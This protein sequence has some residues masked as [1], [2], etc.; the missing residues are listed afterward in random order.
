MLMGKKAG[1]VISLP[2]SA[3]SYSDLSCFC[4]YREYNLEMQPYRRASISSAYA[5][6]I[7]IKNIIYCS[8]S[9]R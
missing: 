8:L 2:L 9:F 1:R 7:I 6:N 3:G 4:K 5:N